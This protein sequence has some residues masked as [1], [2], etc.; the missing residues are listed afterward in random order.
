MGQQQ[1]LLVILVTVI[2]GIATMVAIFN[3]Q[4]SH[5]NSVY[6][7]IQQDILQAQ[8]QS[9]AYVKKA[10]MM[11]GGG[12]SYIGL[13]KEDILLPEQ[14]ENATYSLDNISESEFSVI[15]ESYVGFTVTAN[16]SGESIEWV[17]SDSEDSD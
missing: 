7:A 8:T 4:N 12:G 10:R 5:D 2:V 15:A 13:S 6:E 3:F 9:I 11:G 17:I 14:N 16:I 1:I